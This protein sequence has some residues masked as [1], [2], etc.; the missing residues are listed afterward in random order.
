MSMNNKT[1][2]IFLYIFLLKHKREGNKSLK[3][4]SWTSMCLEHHS[5]VSHLSGFPALY[6]RGQPQLSSPPLC[7]AFMEPQCNKS[8]MNRSTR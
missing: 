5:Y 4:M 1:S 2:F 7:F 8:F 6:S 3:L